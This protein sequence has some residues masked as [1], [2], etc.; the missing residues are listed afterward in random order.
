MKSWEGQ[1]F[2]RKTPSFPP[3]LLR[4]TQY[5]SGAEPQNFKTDYLEEKFKKD[6][7]QLTGPWLNIL[8]LKLCLKDI[9]I[10]SHTLYGVYEFNAYFIVN[11]FQWKF[12]ILYLNFLIDWCWQVLSLLSK[13]F[14]SMWIDYFV[15]FFSLK[16][17]LF[18][19]SVIL[20][21][22]FHILVCK[23]NCKY[24]CL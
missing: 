1:G 5:S 15:I 24:D 17:L 11:M 9:I 8:F 21:R 13:L 12:K 18:T 2:P 23:N 19:V 4:L 3:L 7:I 16:Y 20:F 14:K 6:K 22:Q 10:E